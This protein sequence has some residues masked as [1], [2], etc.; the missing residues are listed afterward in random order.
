MSSLIIVLILF[1]VVYIYLNG[2]IIPKY[3]SKMETC[4]KI[5]ASQNY[6]ERFSCITEMAKTYRDAGVCN[7]IGYR[8]GAT[9]CT[10]EVYIY[11]GD[12]AECGK[13]RDYRDYCEQ[14]IRN[15]SV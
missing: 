4:L 9:K 3:E 13:L 7:Y 6:D 11:I 5:N 1:L 14:Q 2:R 12:I 15:K 10:A 8:D